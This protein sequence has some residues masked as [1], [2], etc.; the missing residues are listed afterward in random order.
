MG[1]RHFISRLT[2]GISLKSSPCSR[3]TRYYKELK[4]SLNVVRI[5]L[6]SWASINLKSKSKWTPLHAA[7]L[8]E[9]VAVI[10]ALVLRGAYIDAKAETIDQTALHTT[11]FNDDSEVVLLLV[12][13]GAAIGIRN[14]IGYGALQ[15][16]VAQG[17]KDILR[18]L[19]AKLKSSS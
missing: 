16:A 15:I 13:Y 3:R 12:D 18:I 14:S 19:I 7:T 1:G 6:D 11:S 2:I 9:N 8:N 17:H 5:L 10:K 4:R